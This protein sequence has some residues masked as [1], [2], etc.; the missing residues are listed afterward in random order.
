MYLYPIRHAAVATAALFLFSTAHSHAEPPP[1]T[2]NVLAEGTGGQPNAA[3][4]AEASRAA[5]AA[6]RKAASE[7]LEGAEKSSFEGM[8][9]EAVGALM[10][11]EDE[12]K[13]SE[14]QKSI[15]NAI[16]KAAFE[17]SFEYET[18][19]IA[20]G[21]GLATL[22]LGDEFRYLNEADAEKLLVEGWG[23]PPGSQTL[24]MIVPNGSSPL[25]ATKG[26]AVVVSYNEDGHVDDDDAEDI[27]YDE[28]LE[29]M[30]EDTAEDSKQRVAQGYEGIELVGWAAPPRYDAATHRLYWAKELA[31]GTAPDHT[32]NYAIRVLGRKGVL[33]L[34]AVAGMNQLEMVREEMERVLPRAEFDSGSKYTDFDPDIDEVA[35]YGIGGLIAGKML[36]KAGL[37]AGL[38]KV[39]VAAKKLVLLGVI[40]VGAFL[41]KLFKGRS[42]GN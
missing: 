29:Q 20:I 5:F 1:T 25:H 26:W 40:G 21:D 13:L 6:L 24:G 2:A 4:E 27:D 38:L 33:E 22:H 10:D 12:S 11:E 39:L 14:E 37:F 31:F 7:H 34:N 28:L 19:D 41:A 23:N 35:A 36:A 3:P 15:R 42:T 30:K 16:A 17:S 9:N 18:G 8:G 32:L